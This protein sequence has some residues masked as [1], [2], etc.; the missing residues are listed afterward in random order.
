MLLD[1]FQ[2]PLELPVGRR[3]KEVLAGEALERFNLPLLAPGKAGVAAVMIATNVMVMNKSTK[4]YQG[5]T[6][7]LL[8]LLLGYCY[9]DL[10]TTA[11]IGLL[12]LVIVTMIWLLLLLL[13]YYCYYDLVTI[14]TIGLP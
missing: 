7:V 12:L 9:Y 11:I 4:P 8:S 2:R 13:G 14:A 1:F 10:V 5:A 3:S 6:V